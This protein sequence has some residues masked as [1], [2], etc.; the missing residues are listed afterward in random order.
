VSWWRSWRFWLLAALAAQYVVLQLATGVEYLD[1]PRNL[2]WG[3]YVLEQPRFLLDAEDVY[4]RINGFPPVPADLAPAGAAIGRSTPLHP[5]WGPLYV[6]VFGGVWWLTGSYTA[7]R[8]VVPLAAG[9]TVLLTYAFGVRYFSRRVGLLAAV[10]LALFPIYREHG[11]L[12]FAEPLSA[13]L[14]GG[15]L[16][17]FLARRTW[18]AAVLGALT[19]LGKIDLIFVYYTT[20]LITAAASLRTP[21]ERLPARHIAICLA[22]PLLVLLP[23]LYLTYIVNA[24]PTT[25]SGGPRLDIF[26]TLAPLMLDQLFTIKPLVALSLLGLLGAAVGW[27]LWRHSGAR[28]MVYCLLAAWLA[29]GCVVALV[30]T[31]TPGASNNPRVIIPAL[32]ALC[33]LV[34]DGFER[35][36]PRWSKITLCYVLLICV[37]IDGVG[38]WYQVLQS[39]ASNAMQPVWEALRAAP[40]GVVLTDAYWDAALYARQPATWF[41]H[42]PAFQRNIMHNLDNFRNYIGAAPIRYVVLPREQAG[43]AYAHSEATQLYERLPLG[44]ELGLPTE[45][46]VTPDVRAFLEQNFPKRLA[47]DF[48]IYTLDG[49]ATTK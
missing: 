25:V 20:L 19:V 33:L 4:D 3:L 44:R 42:D 18:L 48:V 7:L 35:M 16:W 47:G 36:R 6:I 23:W 38:I 46:L 15:A 43:L 5:W 49:Q 32:P 8:M 21:A 40:R 22:S 11:P 27:S 24:R 28:P 41:E 14:I 37:L 9:A 13:L 10:L 31:A 45:P 1:A 34:A 26:V 17:A 2:H 29:A 30:Y 39:G 12:S